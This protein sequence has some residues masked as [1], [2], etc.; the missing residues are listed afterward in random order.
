[1]VT[2]AA[3]SSGPNS[4]ATTHPMVIPVICEPVPCSALLPIYSF[5]HSFSSV[6]ARA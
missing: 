3:G 2:G 6:S 4:S 5:P 1:M